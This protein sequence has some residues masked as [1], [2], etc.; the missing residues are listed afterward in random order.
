MK[1]NLL[2]TITFLFG[3]LTVKAT[4]VKLIIPKNQ[5]TH[6]PY[7]QF[8]LEWS[9]LDNTNGAITYDL[10][11]GTTPTPVLYKSDLDPSI[12][13][14]INDHVFIAES[15]VNINGQPH[16]TAIL[17]A[18]TAL[19]KNTTYYWKIIAKNEHGDFFPSQTFSFTTIR[20][21]TLPTVPTLL[22][23]VNGAQDLITKPTISWS[24]SIDA[25][26]DDV[27]YAI[28][29]KEGNGNFKPITIVTDTSYTFSMPLNDDATY[30]WKIYAIDGYTGERVS[31]NTAS[32][33]IE[34]YQNDTPELGNLLTPANGIKNLGFKIDFKWNAAID[35]DNDAVT[36][37]VYADTN[38]NPQTLIASNIS[39]T[40]VTHIFNNYGAIYWKVVAK[41][42]YGNT[43]TSA[44]YQFSCWENAPNISID[45]IEVESGSFMMGQSDHTQIALGQNIDGSI[46]YSDVTDE[47]PA[48]LIS[49]RDYQI[50]KYE[51]TN[52]QYVS[53]LNSIIDDVVVEF[54]ENNTH[55]RLSFK[56][57]RASLK[58]IPLCQVF[59]QTRDLNERK[60]IP[61][62]PN[63]D[64]PI[65]W[66]GTSFEL[67]PNYANHPVR[68]M[69]YTGV[70]YFAEWGGNYRL[71]SEAEWEFAAL[72]GNHSNG[73]TYS[74]S[75]NLDD[76]AVRGAIST[77][78]VG[79]LSANE[80][81]IYDMSGNVAEICEDIYNVNYY[82][83]S[84]SNNPICTIPS[85]FGRVTRGEYYKLVY[86]AHFRIKKR[87]RLAYEQYMETSGIRLAKSKDYKVS[88]RVLDSHGDPLAGVIISGLPTQ[89]ITN[90][91]GE[92]NTTITGGWSGNITAYKMG[93]TSTNQAINLVNLYENS[94]NNDITLALKPTEYN[95]S[96]YVTDGIKALSNSTVTIEGI[97]YITDANGKIN[98]NNISTGHYNYTAST[99]GFEGASGTIVVN[100]N[101][102]SKTITL[103]KTT[104]GIDIVDSD[105]SDGVKIYPNPFNKAL[106]VE[107]N[108]TATVSVYNVLGKLIKT[109]KIVHKLNLT[110]NQ[111]GMFY[112][113]IRDKDNRVITKKAISK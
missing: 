28:S 40:N 29:L 56:Y 52:T 104:L 91:N 50:S 93:Y 14:P 72:G 12:N 86:E 8:R 85:Y 113:I 61:Y 68:W 31:S 75:N 3:I 33:R 106:Y 49:L 99:Q 88:G 98:I 60:N 16:P 77:A 26:G 36:Y 21:N 23:P 92:Y 41:D 69:Y 4:D 70:K 46:L 42:S 45:M 65:I 71:P 58:G 11:L 87:F 84:P 9:T 53:F 39:N 101:D 10:Y 82:K 64:A 18:N 67:D 51:I 6:I 79:S 83:N 54:S 34:N 63:F 80:L 48:H 109:E 112:L 89:V 97:D 7:D 62:E 44:I 2:I 108:G 111:K 30:Y 37:D 107:Y 78:P 17:F 1:N 32:F 74:G 90:A 38:N 103:F 96:I 110:I 57:K 27:S 66:N 13:G 73:Y 25:D 19:I 20:E 105:A 15:V 24:E 59:D 43:D 47:N 5:E 35:K 22:S 102:V 94:E 76:V 55:R 95:L 81:E 100:N